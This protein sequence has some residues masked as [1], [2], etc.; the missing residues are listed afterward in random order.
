M[1]LSLIAAV[2]KNGEL[3]KNNKLPWNLKEDLDFFRKT[4]E[5][6][7]IIMGRKTFESLPKILPNRRHVILTKKEI[8]VPDEIKV[9]HDIKTLLEKEKNG[10]VI[11]GASIYKQ[12]IDYVLEMYL[13]EIDKEY[14]ADTYFPAFD[15][16]K[17]EYKVLDKC[18]DE[19]EKVNYQHVLYKRK[20]G[21]F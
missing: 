19:N 16:N 14:D 7:T 9:Y 21:Y 10:F 20:R 4:T 12:L 6:N 1:S 2:G 8:S 5:N 15:K 11:G 17:F 18:Y 13:T 3:G